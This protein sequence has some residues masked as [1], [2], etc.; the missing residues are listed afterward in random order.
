MAAAHANAPQHPA[1]C[2]VAEY[3]GGGFRYTNSLGRKYENSASNVSSVTFSISRYGVHAHTINL[4]PMVT[5]AV[6]IAAAERYLSES[7]T[8]DH[9]AQIRDDL[10]GGDM[11]WTEAAALYRCKGDCL[12]SARFL[13]VVEL[14]DG[15]MALHCGS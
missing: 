4:W 7:L 9:F 13:E 12:S 3:P 11:S 6:A 8:E 5:E 10:F 14:S 15:A 2:I 1:P